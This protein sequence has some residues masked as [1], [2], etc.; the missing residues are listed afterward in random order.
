[1]RHYTQ[2][3]TE[4]TIIRQLGAGSTSRVFELSSNEAVKA[5][6]LKNKAL[7]EREAYAYSYLKL[8]SKRARLDISGAFV[9]PTA[10]GEL[11]ATDSRRRLVIMMPI[12]SATLKIIL[13]H[14]FQS[15]WSAASTN[16]YIA[17]LKVLSFSVVNMLIMLEKMQIHHGDLKPGNILYDQQAKKFVLADFGNALTYEEFKIIDPNSQEPI[18]P[19]HGSA[20]FSSPALAANIRK[21]P[22]QDMM[23]SMAQVLRLALGRPVMFE[24]E[25][26]R[27]NRAFNP[28]AML[29][30]KA[31]KYEQAMSKSAGHAVTQPLT[32]AAIKQATGVV[33][34][35]QLMIA[36]MEEVTLQHFPTLQLLHN[37]V[38]Y[39][40]NLSVGIPRPPQRL[41]TQAVVELEEESEATAVVTPS[42]VAQSSGASMFDASFLSHIPAYDSDLFPSTYMMYDSDVLFSD[43]E[44]GSSTLLSAYGYRPQRKC[45][46]FVLAKEKHLVDADEG[47]NHAIPADV[48]RDVEERR[49]REAELLANGEPNLTGAQVSLTLKPF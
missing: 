49:D 19:S 13:D 35:I 10:F 43:L 30:H 36:G 39:M 12:C 2:P 9:Q 41:A 28:V 34:L 24:E 38:I 47:F 4:K 22:L 17:M 16:E 23:W 15:Q 44:C 18:F 1:M 20:P 33:Q 45:Y 14:N 46:F 25:M 48:L 21:S 37:A 42:S 8:E 40:G 27:S 11:I 29:A 7:F 26:N 31:K 3:E 32:K 5:F 6:L